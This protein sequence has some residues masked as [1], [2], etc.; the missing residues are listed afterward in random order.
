M[1]QSPSCG[2]T[3]GDA[4]VTADISG[5]SQFATKWMSILYCCTSEYPKSDCVPQQPQP[6]SQQASIREILDLREGGDKADQGVGKEV[7]VNGDHGP[8]R[9]GSVKTI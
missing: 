4:D 3:S 7:I 6:L 1:A 5:A 9:P 8:E 2:N